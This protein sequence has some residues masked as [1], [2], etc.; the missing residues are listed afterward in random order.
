MIGNMKLLDVS[1][2]L[3]LKKE[4]KLNW[5]NRFKNGRSGAFKTNR[6]QSGFR[7]LKKKIKQNKQ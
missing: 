4:E 2:M 1:S 5:S 6:F 3:K 7:D